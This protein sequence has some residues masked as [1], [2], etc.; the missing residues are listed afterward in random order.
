MYKLVLLRLFSLHIKLC[1]ISSIR[2]IL[3]YLEIIKT[4]NT[5]IA[6]DKAQVL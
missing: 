4:K 5:G 3:V 6:L 1:L 2:E